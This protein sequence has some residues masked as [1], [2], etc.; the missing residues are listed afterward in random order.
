[1]IASA[2]FQYVRDPST[3][4]MKRK[5][6]AKRT[7]AEEIARGAALD[8]LLIDF[9]RQSEAYKA[10]WMTEDNPRDILLWIDRTWRFREEC[11]PDLLSRGGYHVI[12][13]HSFEW[14]R[15]RRSK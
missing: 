10:Q 1:L 14:P 4:K 13:Q 5:K 9:N 11:D 7:E 8:Q 12:K 6:G 2:A 3:G 15:P